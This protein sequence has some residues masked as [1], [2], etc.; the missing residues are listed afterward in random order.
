MTPVPIAIGLSAQRP[1]PF[2]RLQATFALLVLVLSLQGCEQSTL[3]GTVANTRGERLPG[4]S[5]RIEGSELSALTNALG[6]YQFRFSQGAETLLFDKTGYAPALLELTGGEGAAPVNGT[7][8]LW[9]L[10][11]REG[12]YLLEE[13]EYNPLTR[14]VP[15]QTLMQ[16]GSP[17]RITRLELPTIVCYKT[18]RFDTR[19]TGL[20]V[21]EARFG[22]GSDSTF[23][24]FRRAG[25]VKVDLT[26]LDP[27]EGLL[28]TVRFAQP[29]EAGHYA[30]HWGALEGFTA[31][32]SRVFL[33]TVEPPEVEAPPLT[34]EFT[35]PAIEEP[36]LDNDTQP[37]R[38]ETE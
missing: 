33:F 25:T 26:P 37:R 22:V 12:V 20:K 3:R 13:S 1:F 9:R 24:V 19:V 31:L 32:E 38:V 4:V 27:L 11:V 16:Y 17:E 36:E 21:E 10:P 18:P 28:Q 5:V 30:I 15:E 35:E 8:K 34:L 14:D 2:A 23:A 7:M 29:L 6:E